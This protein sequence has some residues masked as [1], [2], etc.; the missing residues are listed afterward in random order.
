MIWTILARMN[1]V[2]T[3]AAPGGTWYESAMLWA[4]EQGVTDG[5]SPLE[6]ITREQFAVML[7]RNAGSTGEGGSLVSFSDAASVSGYAA[8]AMQWAVSRGILQGS[9]GRLNPQEPATRAEIAAMI[10]RYASG[11]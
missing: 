7:W 6:D 3:G 9:G 5:S 8:R 1:Q 4:V 10:M 11:V 2:H